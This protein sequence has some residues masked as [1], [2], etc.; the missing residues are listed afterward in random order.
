M[1]RFD[2]EDEPNGFMDMPCRCGC[3]K[4]FD[5]SDGYS[6][7]KDNKV[8]CGDCY[9]TQE[10]IQKLRDEYYELDSGEKPFKREK[11]KILLHLKVLGAELRES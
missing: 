6:S 7:K 2:C 8:I 1:K 11:K 4:W 3:G 5:L 9:E 10:L